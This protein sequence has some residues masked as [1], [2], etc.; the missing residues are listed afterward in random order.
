MSQIRVTRKDIFWIVDVR[1]D[2]AKSR[3]FVN[4]NAARRY[5][6]TLGV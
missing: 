2:P 3:S 1:Q 4:P 5:L 6:K